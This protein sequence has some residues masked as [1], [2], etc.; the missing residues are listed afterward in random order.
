MSELKIFDNWLS[1][2]YFNQIKSVVLDSKF[3]WNFNDVSV[4]ASDREFDD[5]NEYQFTHVIY[6]NSRPMSESYD[7][8]SQLFFK[9]GAVVLLKAKL[10]LN[11]STKEIREKYF[12]IDIPSLYTKDVGY[13]TGIFYINTNNGY[14]KFKTGEVVE[15]MENRFIIFD[16]Y[17]PHCGSTCTDQK[18]RVVLNVNWI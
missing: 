18:C 11:P 3:N 14:T 17:E 13:K 12:H 5:P 15:S 7:L 16:G 6:A 8:F 1:E 9:L 10:N 4:Y 2:K